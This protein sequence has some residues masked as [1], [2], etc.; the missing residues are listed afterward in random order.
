MGFLRVLALFFVA[1]TMVGAETRTF[2]NNL[3]SSKA[4]NLFSNTNNWAGN[5]LPVA[6]DDVVIHQA[7]GAEFGGAYRKKKGEK[8]KENFL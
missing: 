7:C 3:G 4:N 5:T 6:G 2:R 8:R 1:V